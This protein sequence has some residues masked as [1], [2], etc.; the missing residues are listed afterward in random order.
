MAITNELV[1]C[2][3]GLQRSGNHAIIPWIMEN[4][5]G[6]RVHLNDIRRMD[7]Y[8][9]FNGMTVYGLSYYTCG[10]KWWGLNRHVLSRRCYSGARLGRLGDGNRELDIGRI[11]RARKNLLVLSYED[12]FLN[13]SRVRRFL[14]DPARAIGPSRRRLQ[15]LILRDPYNHFA[16]L[17][18]YEASY[19]S[20][21]HLTLKLYA[22]MWK[23]YAA[24]FA[25]DST[26]ADTEYLCVNYNRWCES[27]DYRREVARA[28]GF[29]T[30]GR[31]FNQVSNVGGGSSFQGVVADARDLG[32]QERW[33]SFQHDAFYR[34]LF[35]DQIA[36]YGER[37]FGMK[38]EDIFAE[39]VAIHQ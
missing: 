2:V 31:P 21:H 12:V 6:P 17:L 37:L 27:S 8:V 38:R 22:E 24:V 32:V 7:P 4:A 39:P 11:R 3:F 19:N 29:T 9:D 26:L 10:R 5:E 15:V 34:S 14:A 23:Q 25:G 30:D 13:D 33:R 1:L 20:P 16:S 36:A 28:V 18:K 35:D